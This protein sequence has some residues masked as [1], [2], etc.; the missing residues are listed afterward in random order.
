MGNDNDDDNTTCT[1]R[2]AKVNYVNPGYDAALRPWLSLVH[3]LQG[4]GRGVG[5]A[6]G[7]AGGVRNG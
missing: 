4:A 2:D 5:C 1:V 6:A 7:G 3:R